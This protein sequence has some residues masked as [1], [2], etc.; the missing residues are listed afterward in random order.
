MRLRTQS[1]QNLDG[2]SATI[3][4]IQWYWRVLAQVASVMILGGFLMLS[5]TYDQDPNIRISSLG[6]G[7]FALAILLA[8]ICATVLVCVVIRDLSFRT[9]E[10]FR[11]AL[12]SCAIGFLTVFYNFMISSSYVWNIRAILIAAVAGVGALIYAFLLFRSS[13]ISSAASVRSR[14]IAPSIAIGEHH[15]ASPSADDQSRYQSPQYYQ[16]YIKNM[17]PTAST[18]YD[19]TQSANARPTITEDEMQRQQM[20]MLLLKQDQS[21]SAESSSG[22]FKIEWQGQEQEQDTPVHPYFRPPA[23]G[24]MNSASTYMGSQHGSMRSAVSMHLP[25]GSMPSWDGVWRGVASQPS[26]QGRAVTR[27]DRRREIELGR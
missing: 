8:G 1:Y 15:D 19:P 2:Q 16:N 11:P 9:T 14:S 13:R 10:V 26:L 6:L 12:A 4:Y 17:F 3:V 20:L 23:N 27:E 5:I 7:I 24:T 22:T 25:A 21:A 18:T